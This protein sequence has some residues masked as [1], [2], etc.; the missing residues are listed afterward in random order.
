MRFDN[1]G[2]TGTTTADCNYDQFPGQ[3]V[4]QGNILVR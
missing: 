1:S 4:V 2:Y 3:V